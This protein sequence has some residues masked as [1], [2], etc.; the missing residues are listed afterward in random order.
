MD[1]DKLKTFRSEQYTSGKTPAEAMQP[2][3][4][5]QIDYVSY[6]SIPLVINFGKREETE[7]GVLHVDTKLFAA[8]A[9]PQDAVQD[10][11]E[12]NVFRITRSRTKLESELGEWGSN[13]YDI[14]DKTIEFLE[15][16]R[17]VIIPVLQLYKKCRTGATKRD[18][19]PG[20][21]PS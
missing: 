8:M 15:K 17:L 1:R 18:S 14:E 19:A 20:A 2:R 12:D 7:L 9:R 21:Q 5:N 10:P 4:L 3:G 16:M 13:I 6:V 11:H